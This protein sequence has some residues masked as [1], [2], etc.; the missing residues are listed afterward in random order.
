MSA[1]KSVVKFLADRFLTKDDLL[2]DLLAQQDITERANSAI[3]FFKREAALLVPG[4]K[5]YAD[6]VKAAED[7]LVTHYRAS[8]FVQLCRSQVRKNAKP[9]YYTIAT[10]GQIIEAHKADHREDDVAPVVGGEAAALLAT[11]NDA[12]GA[13]KSETNFIKRR[14]IVRKAIVATLPGISSDRAAALTEL[15]LLV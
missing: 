1:I 8:S 11:I 13:A 2:P 9:E 7:L 6:A 3:G 12:L 4:G 5:V 10:I 15:T 14:S